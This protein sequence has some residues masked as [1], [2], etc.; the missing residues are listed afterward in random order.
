MKLKPGKWVGKRLTTDQRKAQRWYSQAQKEWCE[1][2]EA[3]RA[4]PDRVDGRDL[5]EAKAAEKAARR[6]RQILEKEARA[7]EL[8]PEVAE[9]LVLLSG[10][11]WI[12]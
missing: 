4:S 3:L 9:S 8:F 10:E 12:K 7:I 5:T 11:M 1:L 2:C 6:V